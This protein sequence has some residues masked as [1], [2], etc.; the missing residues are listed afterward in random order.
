MRA[1]DLTKETYHQIKELFYAR[2]IR[3]F[4]SHSFRASVQFALEVGAVVFRALC[5]SIGLSQ[6]ENI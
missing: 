6:F 4:L 2:L 3:A 5:T 1:E